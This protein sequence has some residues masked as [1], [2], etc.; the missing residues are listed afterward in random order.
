MANLL[1]LIR[2]GAEAVSQLHFHLVF[3]FDI[4]EFDSFQAVA[5]GVFPDGVHR[6]RAQRHI[7]AVARKVIKKPQ[8]LGVIG[9][10]IPIDFLPRRPAADFGDFFL[11]LG[12]RLPLRKAHW[13]SGTNHEARDSFEVWLG[14]RDSNPDKQSQSLLSYR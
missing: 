13:E 9:Q 14:D 4:T 8:C 1:G 10:A 11:T 2:A 7:E 12:K 6:D 3:C 5:K